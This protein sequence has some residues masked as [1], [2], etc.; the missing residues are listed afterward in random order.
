MSL[1]LDRCFFGICLNIVYYLLVYCHKIIRDL[2]E[3]FF[4]EVIFKFFEECKSIFVTGNNF[5]GGNFMINWVKTDLQWLL[6]NS[7]KIEIY[8]R[9]EVIESNFIESPKLKSI[10][11]LSIFRTH[12]C[13]EKL[14]CVM[15]KN[16]LI[17]LKK[18]GFGESLKIYKFRN[19]LGILIVF[20]VKL[21]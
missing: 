15:Q 17:H 16:L 21:F 9:L 14:F 20:F 11:D 5:R 1:Y 13:C 18:S 19:S 10:I 3:L 6:L 8:L 4:I 12:F 2:R 7:Q